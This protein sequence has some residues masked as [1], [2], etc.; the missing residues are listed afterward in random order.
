MRG[1]LAAAVIQKMMSYITLA[2][3]KAQA[4]IILNSVIIPLALTGLDDPD[5]KVMSSFAIIAGVI[6]IF[7]AIM[8]I[9]PKRREG[10]KPDGSHN[11]LHFGDIASLREHEYLARFLPIYN[12]TR[13]LS[14][15]VVKDLHDMSHRIIRPKFFWLKVSYGSFFLLNLVGIIWTMAQMWFFPVFG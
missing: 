2:D 8:C 1:S 14:R 10:T 7:G 6:S 9:Y 5:F 13:R 12:D 15:E 4:A 3:Q 11:Y